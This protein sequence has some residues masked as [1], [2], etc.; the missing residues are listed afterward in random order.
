[1]TGANDRGFRGGGGRFQVAI[2]IEQHKSG[3]V[4]WGNAQPPLIS[5]APAAR[6]TTCVIV[7][8][9]DE[10]VSITATLQALHEQ[11]ALDGRPCDRKR[12][13]IIVLANNCRDATAEIARAFS[14]SHPTLHLHVVE[15]AL[16]EAVA[17]IGAVRRLLMD[18]ACRRLLE[19]G[20]RRGIIA[21]TDADTIVAPTWLAAIEAEMRRGADVVGGR[22]I[23]REERG[24]DENAEPSSRLYHLRDVAYGHLIAELESLLD[25]DPADPWPRHHQHF[26]ANLAMTAETYE[27]AGGLPAVPEL[28]DMAF[29]DALRRIDARIRHSPSVRVITSARRMG[30]V[31]VGLSTQLGEW[32]ALA[33]AGRLPLVESPAAAEHRVRRRR[34][35]RELWYYARAD[36]M[37]GADAL[38]AVARSL[39]LDRRWLALEVLRSQTFGIFVERVLAHGGAGEDARGLEPLAEITTAIAMLRLRLAVLRRCRRVPVL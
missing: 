18:E 14:R 34:A 3:L 13:E 29:H 17:T 24:D 12:Y 1:M 4:P 11:V 35:L 33:R 15:R 37:P 5:A 9:R 7:P 19:R 22:I 10:A 31:A 26:G 27:R 6:C 8:A 39:H 25:P 32:D 20:R 28:E 38:P 2:E 21:S 16:P 36:G 30:R 23:A